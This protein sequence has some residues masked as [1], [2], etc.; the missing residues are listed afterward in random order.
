MKRREPICWGDWLNA[1]VWLALLAFTF[2]ALS[3]CG[4]SSTGSAPMDP[5]FRP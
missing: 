5:W 4:G 1:A 3:Q 2:W